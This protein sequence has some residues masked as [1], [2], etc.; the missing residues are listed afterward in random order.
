M[1]VHDRVMASHDACTSGTFQVLTVASLQQ[2]KMEALIPT[3]TDCEVRSVIKFFNAQSK[4]LIEIHHTGLVFGELRVQIPVL[5]KRFG[6]I[7]VVSLSQQ[8]QRRVGFTLPRSIYPFFIKFTNQK[9]WES[10]NLQEDPRYE[11]TV[12]RWLQSQAA[13]LYNTGIQKLVPLYDKCLNSGG[14]C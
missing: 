10:N 13:N 5:T 4:A 11:V 6:V 9:Y 7:F 2:L 8:G 14:E 3:P 12:T 1:H